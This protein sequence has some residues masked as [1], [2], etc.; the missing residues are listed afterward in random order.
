M[1]IIAFNIVGISEKFPTILKSIPIKNGILFYFFATFFEILW[2]YLYKVIKME[3]IT[4]AKYLEKLI[5]KYSNMVYRLALIRTKTKE[6]KNC[7]R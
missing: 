7:S 3:Y 1:A 2:Y 6:Q 5:D 4:K